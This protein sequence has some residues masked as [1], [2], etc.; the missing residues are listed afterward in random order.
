MAM[1]MPL[2][3]EQLR[4]QRHRS[5][6]VHQPRFLRLLLWWIT[7]QLNQ[8]VASC[9]DVGPFCCATFAEPSDLSCSR[10]RSS[11]PRPLQAS[12]ITLSLH[13]RL[14]LNN[15]IQHIAHTTIRTLLSIRSSRPPLPSRSTCTWS[16][17]SASLSWP[18]R[19]CIA[20]APFSR[21]P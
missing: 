4:L 15:P 18:T 2:L 14:C 19:F 6:A 5:M 17:N 1:A 13:P 10:S 7:P 16:N 12:T 11:P 3:R 9:H 20:R 21:K 8:P